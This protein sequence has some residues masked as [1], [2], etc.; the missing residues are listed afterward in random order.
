MNLETTHYLEVMRRK[1]NA[2]FNKQFEYTVHPSK[3]TSVRTNK[4]RKLVSSKN[5]K[6]FS[7][8]RNET[9]FAMACIPKAPEIK[10]IRRK[11]NVRKSF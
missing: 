7:H 3:S 9:S 1:C 2:S 4:S 8:K 6:T 11:S 5:G 10:S